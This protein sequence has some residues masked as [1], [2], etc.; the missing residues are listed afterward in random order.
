MR[1][2][3]LYRMFLHS[4]SV[5]FEWPETGEAFSISVPLPGDLE[6]VITAL[7]GQGPADL[8]PPP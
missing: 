7:G 8:A 3:G 1:R 2:F 5:A 6:A 4:Q